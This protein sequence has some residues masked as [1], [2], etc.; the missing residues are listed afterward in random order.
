MRQP[1][2]TILLAI[3][4]SLC[5]AQSAFL[6]D[7]SRVTVND[8]TRPASVHHPAGSPGH[9]RATTVTLGNASNAFTTLLTYQNQV[10]YE[11]AINAVVFTHRHDPADF[12]GQGGTGTMRFDVSTDGGATWSI[13]HLLTPN[14]FDG[15]ADTIIG[16]RYPN[17]TIHNPP[18]NTDPANA[19]VVSTGMTLNTPDTALGYLNTGYLQR[20]SARLDGS[21]ATCAFQD[22]YGDRTT[23]AAYG[24]VSKDDGTVWA[25]SARY[26]NDP[27]NLDTIG[28]KDFRINKGVWNDAEQRMDWSDVAT[29]SPQ[30]VVYG[31]YLGTEAK[32]PLIFSWN[33]GFSPDGQI[34]YAVI[35]GKE[36]DGIPTGP[37][38]LVW[39]SVDGGDTWDQLPNHDFSLEQ[40]ALDNIAPA[41][42]T[43]LPRPYF[44]D[45]DLTVDANGTLHMIAS[46]ISQYTGT[47]LDSSGFYFAD[48]ATQ[49][50]VH[51]ATSDGVSW[52]ISTL[53]EKY[54]ADVQW[55][56]NDGSEGPFQDDHPQASRTA[57]GNHL[58]FTWN[59]SY[60]GSTTNAFPEIHGVGYDVGGQLWTEPKSLSVGTDADAVAWWHTVSPV[61]ISDGDDFDFELPT[62]FASPGDFADVP[63]GFSYLKGIGF[64]GDEFIVG[65]EELGRTGSVSVFPNPSEGHFTLSLV[66]TGPVDVRVSDVSGRVVRSLRTN[67]PQAQLDLTDQPAG[68]YTL[69]AMGEHARYV[70]KLI[71]R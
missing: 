48:I 2:P 11:P 14:I 71:V 58:F 20:S 61:C 64:N 55:P 26:S 53:S 13:D 24:L 1:Y 28:F 60:D 54:G 27:L 8:G 46:V 41:T 56:M 59:R 38:P 12:G 42:D 50:I 18:G 51:T 37:M 34:G 65:L 3:T 4:T 17:G 23:Y 44:S 21:D 7:A 52:T 9:D 39:K 68:C 40:W 25:L 16:C 33:M 57:D 67:A 36:Y 15:S 63:C 29:L 45:F 32:Y 47:S 10:S 43:D 70:M 22:F 19:F 5:T 31:D 35:I 6:P 66:N 62:V 69:S 49:F 30:T